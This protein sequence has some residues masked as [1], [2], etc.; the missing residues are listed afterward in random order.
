VPPEVSQRTKNTR[1]DVHLSHREL[2][3]G[4]KPCYV[5]AR[6]DRPRDSD[7]TLIADRDDSALE[8][9]RRRLIRDFR[10][11]A[12]EYERRYEMPSS[13]VK[14][15]AGGGAAPRN[16]RDRAWLL[17]LAALVLLGNPCPTVTPR[18]TG[19]V[20]RNPREGDRGLQPALHSSATTSSRNSRRRRSSGAASSTASMPSNPRVQGSGFLHTA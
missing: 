19:A 3:W 17:V 13:Q 14:T 6:A 8:Q 20:P 7:M 1:T 16:R 15:G 4:R 11:E 2:E 9:N 5:A 10:R 18:I 12:A